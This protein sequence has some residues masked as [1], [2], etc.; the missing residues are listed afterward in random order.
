M[1]EGQ[2]VVLSTVYVRVW[3]MPDWSGM[4][5]VDCVGEEDGGREG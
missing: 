2:D 4:Q 1:C 5:S 3:S